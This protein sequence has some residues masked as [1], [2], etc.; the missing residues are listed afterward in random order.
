MQF[1][2]KRGE[3]RT[4]QAQCVSCPAAAMLWVATTPALLDRGIVPAVSHPN[5]LAL[6]SQGSRSC[7]RFSGCQ[8]G[9]S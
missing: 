8:D 4:S 2:A 1:G 9:S 5:L 3:S 6:C 7:H